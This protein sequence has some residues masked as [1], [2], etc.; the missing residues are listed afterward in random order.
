[1]LVLNFTYKTFLIEFPAETTQ[2][3]IY[4]SIF[5]SALLISAAYSAGIVS[6]LMAS[7]HLPFA[8][9]DQFAEDATYGLITVINSAEYN[10]F[11]VIN[12]SLV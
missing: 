8:T 9:M 12:S 2:R 5:L 7:S 6:S 1:M 11:K 3:I 10:A 4:T